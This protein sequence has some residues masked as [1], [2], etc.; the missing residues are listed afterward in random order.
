MVVLITIFNENC[1]ET[2][3]RMSDE[4]KKVGLVLTSPFYNTNKKSLGVHTI[5]NGESGFTSVRYDMPLDGMTNDE[6]TNFTIN[7]FELFDKILSN[8]GCVLYNMSYG[9]ENTD[10]MFLALNGII[11]QTNF[12]I[13]DVIVWK[14]KMAFPNSC[15]P[16]K[17]TRICEFVY[18]LCRKDELKS[19]LTNKQITSYR[20][21]GQPAYENIYNYIEARNNDGGCPYNKC[22]FSSDLCLQLL[23]I[24]GKD[25]ITVYDPFMG[26]GTTA[27]ACKLM[28]YD[29]IGSELSPNQVKF[30]YDRLKKTEQVL[31]KC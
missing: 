23:K 3:K 16:N 15:S 2:M 6:Y 21:T 27:V 10:G 1:L 28:G 17:L 19:F 8:N 9:S 12:T 30:A 18:V 4:G 31:L 22:T 13:A 25:G 5:E 24:Y 14:K 11:T 20:K 7:V 26:S 29:C